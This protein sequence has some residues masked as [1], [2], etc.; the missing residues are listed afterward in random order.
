[1]L[2]LKELNKQ[3][4]N[5]V[6]ASLAGCLALLERNAYQDNN[7][8]TPDPVP[9]GQEI[10]DMDH[11]LRCILSLGQVVVQFGW[12]CRPHYWDENSERWGEMAMLASGVFEV[13][14][15]H[16]NEAVTFYLDHVCAAKSTGMDTETGNDLDQ[17]GADTASADENELDGASERDMEA[18]AQLQHQDRMEDAHRVDLSHVFTAVGQSEFHTSAI[19]QTHTCSATYSQ[20]QFHTAAVDQDGQAVDS[21][22][23]CTASVVS[24]SEAP[25][26]D[27]CQSEARTTAA[28]HSEASHNTEDQSATDAMPGSKSDLHRLSLDTR[29]S[30]LIKYKVQGSA[31]EACQTG[32]GSGSN[33]ANDAATV[34]S[35]KVCALASSWGYYSYRKNSQPRSINS[36]GAPAAGKLAVKQSVTPYLTRCTQTEDYAYMDVAMQTPGT[37]QS[38]VEV[39]Y[40]VGGALVANLTPDSQAVSSSQTLYSSN[41]RT[42]QQGTSMLYSVMHVAGSTPGKFTDSGAEI[43]AASGAAVDSATQISEDLAEG[44]AEGDAAEL[45][46]AGQTSHSSAEAQCETTSHYPQAEMMAELFEDDTLPINVTTEST[47]VADDANSTVENVETIF[48]ND[49]DEVNLFTVTVP[50]DHSDGEVISDAAIMMSETV[51]IE[52][53]GMV[54]VDGMGGLDPNE[55]PLAEMSSS[56]HKGWFEPFVCWARRGGGVV[57]VYIWYFVGFQSFI[58]CTSTFYMCRTSKIFVLCMKGIGSNV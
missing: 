11:L 12:W 21:S 30:A 19:D 22:E 42:G 10:G 45:G 52:T 20:L 35:S 8:T 41:E 4:N 33:T 2:Q 34:Q 36:T 31:T 39:Y 29:P 32:N 3:L 47:N 25:P 9:Q 15:Q 24:L 40:T 56:D 50:A 43:S 44:K 18:A 1:M 5:E 58:N 28:G 13:S 27:L 51:E 46:T 54:E 38:E 37:S 57:L 55:I 16:L 14:M 17:G 53:D 6:L 49:Q 23:P 7:S 26:P 48:Q